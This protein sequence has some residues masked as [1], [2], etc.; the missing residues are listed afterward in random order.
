LKA[1]GTIKLYLISGLLVHLDFDDGLIHENFRPFAV[2]GDRAD[3]KFHAVF[4]ERPPKPNDSESIF[5]RT[6][7]EAWVS[8]DKGIYVLNFDA[9]D[10]PNGYVISE[11]WSD[12]TLY[13]DPAFSRPSGDLNAKL[14]ERLWLAVR[15]LFTP[16]LILRRGLM[17]HAS[18]IEWNGQG[19]MFPAPSGTGKSTHAHLWHRRFGVTILDGDQTSCRL[20]D[21]F[22][23]VFGLPWCGTSGEFTNASRPLRAIVFLEQSPSNSIRRLT[24]SEGAV[25]LFARCFMHISNEIMTDRALQTIKEIVGRTD[26]YL[27]KCRPDFEAVE[28]VKKCLEKE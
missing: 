17:I 8:K 2:C 23:V 22:P 7:T 9:A 21:G 28:L 15:E 25:R 24:L 13:I 20:V 1:G 5:F 18:S 12:C 14:G 6:Y 26:C 16:A 10:I 27:L 4:A 19:V 3:I 11:D